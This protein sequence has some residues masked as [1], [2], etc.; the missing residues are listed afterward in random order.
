MGKICYKL[1]LLLDNTSFCIKDALQ[2]YNLDFF[3][4]A[5][6]SNIPHPKFCTEFCIRIVVLFFFLVT[7][8]YCLRNLNNHQIIVSDETSVLFIIFS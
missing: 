1:E 4:N 7:V 8:N 6:L 5:L 2:L 3:A